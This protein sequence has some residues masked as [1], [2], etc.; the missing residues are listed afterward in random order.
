ML[1]SLNVHRCTVTHTAISA[2]NNG[3]KRAKRNGGHQIEA[4][5]GPPRPNAARGGNAQPAPRPRKTESGF[6]HF[7]RLAE[8]RRERF[9]YAGR[10]QALFARGHLPHTLVEHLRLVWTAPERF[11]PRPGHVRASQDATCHGFSSSR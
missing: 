1:P 7:A 2:N 8:Q 11:W 6:F 9:L 4:A 3:R 10:I 5:T